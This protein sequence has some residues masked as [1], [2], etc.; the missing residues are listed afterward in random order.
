MSESTSNGADHFGDEK[1]RHEIGLEPGS[2]MSMKDSEKNVTPNAMYSVDEEPPKPEKP[3]GNFFKR[4]YDH[5]RK[6]VLWTVCIFIL[7]VEMC[8]R[9]TYYTFAGSQR[10]HLQ[11][12]GYSNAQ[13]TSMN[14]AFSILCYITPLFGVVLAAVS[15][16]PTVESTGLYLFSTMALITLGCGGIKPNIANFGG[17]HYFYL[18][19]NVGSTVSYGYLVTLATNGQPPVISEPMGFFAAYMIASG[20]FVLCMFIFVA[21]TSKYHR[22][23]CGGDSLR[24][25][26]YYIWQGA[27]RTHRGKVA[28]FGWCSVF[29]FLIVAVAQSF[30]TDK[31]V[32]H[33]L[34]YLAL[35]LASVACVTLVFAHAKNH[36]LDGIPDE[37]SGMLTLEEAQGTFDTV[38]IVLIVNTAFNICYNQMS[39]SFQAQ[40]CQMNLTVGSG[41]RQINGAF[42]NIGD[43]F[44]IIA[45]TPFFEGFFLPLITRLKGSPV[46]GMQQLIVG[47]FVASTSMFVAA[48]LEFARRAAPVMYNA[49]PSNCA[50]PGVPMSDISGF[51][52]FI[53]FAL[54]GVAEVLINPYMY[55][56]VYTQTPPRA[57]SLSQ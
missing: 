10:N 44:A 12:M 38:P 29:I 5:Y 27:K 31:N 15:A 17:D 30:I 21:G 33:G 42:F 7:V 8:E 32:A 53:P 14:A 43:S 3:H 25:L 4:V 52:M 40:A 2:A 22:L 6:S 23:P 35:G 36:Y 18:V 45:F 37:P 46:T 56:F 57:R 48:G 41:T 26:I 49:P 16:Y 28:L 11:R 13:A 51:L 1:S 47:L 34:S 39:G 50:P 54:I 19:I 9:L 20:C 24:G 55:Y